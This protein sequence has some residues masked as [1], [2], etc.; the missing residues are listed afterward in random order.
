MTKI[1]RKEGSVK[2]KREKEI[3]GGFDFVLSC[4]LGFAFYTTIYLTIIS[5]SNNINHIKYRK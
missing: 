1:S 5:V 2:N 4:K 3:K